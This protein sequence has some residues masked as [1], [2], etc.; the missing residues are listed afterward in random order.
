MVKKE[1]LIITSFLC[2]LEFFFCRLVGTANCDTNFSLCTSN[3]VITKG[4]N[5]LCEFKIRFSEDSMGTFR[6][7]IK[8]SIVV[9]KNSICN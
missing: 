4:I 8:L 2:K 5:Q 7:D 9:S 3:L 1:I 6:T